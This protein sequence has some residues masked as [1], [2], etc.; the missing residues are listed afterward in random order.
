MPGVDRAVGVAA[1]VVGLRVHVR[2]LDCSARP[3]RDETT[4]RRRAAIRFQTALFFP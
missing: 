1:D 4:L 3:R 2:S